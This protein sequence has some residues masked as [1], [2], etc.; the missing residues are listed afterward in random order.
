VRGREGGGRALP[1]LLYP[2]AYAAVF[3]ATNMLIFRWYLAPPLPPYFLGIV[4][5]AWVV[6]GG[7]ASALR[8][9]SMQGVI[10]AVFVA[11]W[12]GLSLNAWTLH[13]SH[14]PD[15]PAPEMAFIELEL[16]YEEAG[17]L[18]KEA[19]GVTAD[20]VVA[21]G[22]IGAVGFYSSATIFD[23]IGLVTPGTTD[24]Y[25]VDEHILVEGVN[26][27]I[28]PAL[29]LDEMPDFLVVVESYV[30][31]GLMQDPAFTAAYGDPVEV[32]D[33]EIY[34]GH[35]MLIFQRAD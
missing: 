1:A 14:G 19:Y 4:A 32:L 2:W 35:G 28:P 20:T 5:G 26:Y 34:E 21:A 3:A 30:R 22:D 16:R 18:L 31:L 12:L 33:I 13:P 29:V 25:P 8:R 24:Y 10:F 23:T 6:A 9:A 7:V 27:A 15:R 11:V 17:R